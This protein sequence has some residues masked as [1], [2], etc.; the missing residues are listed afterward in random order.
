[1]TEPAPEVHPT[2]LKLRDALGPALTSEDASTG[3]TLLRF[4]ESFA[5]QLGEVD[6]VV[7][8][9]DDGM[10]WA[11]E[12]DPDLTNRP[13]WL[14]QFVGVEVPDGLTD[15]QQRDLVRDRPAIRRGTP[16]TLQ[17]VAAQFLIGTRIVDLFERYGG[18]PYALRVRTYAAQRP[19]AG[20]VDD[21]LTEGGDVLTTEGG[22]VLDGRERLSS[23][24]ILPALLAAKPAGLILTH[25]VTEGPVP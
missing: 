7:R 12:L 1:M 19:L 22:D 8:D 18:N 14:G 4:L 6:D 11:R 10:G 15:E 5:R 2:T 23:A 16:S 21:L 13:S 9:T 3:W 20:G 24:P 25:E 17:A